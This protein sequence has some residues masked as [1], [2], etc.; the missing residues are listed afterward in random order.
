MDT[1]CAM[2]T[3]WL[4]ETPCLQLTAMA[5]GFFLNWFLNWPLTCLLPISYQHKALLCLFTGGS[6]VIFWTRC[7]IVLLFRRRRCQLWLFVPVCNIL[8]QTYQKWY[9]ACTRIQVICLANI[10]KYFLW[11]LFFEWYFS[12]VLHNNFVCFLSL[13]TTCYIVFRSHDL[14]SWVLGGDFVAE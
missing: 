8:H 12:A 11:L 4:I 10:S 14:I 1:F 2:A 9:E 5:G 7:L 6:F 13:K 3:F